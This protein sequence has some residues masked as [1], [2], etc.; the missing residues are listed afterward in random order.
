MRRRAAG[1]RDRRRIGG[2][3]LLIRTDPDGCGPAAAAP[4]RCRPRAS[5]TTPW[6]SGCH[7][8]SRSKTNSRSP[9][10]RNINAP[11]IA[12]IALPDAAE[13]RDAA[14]HD[15]GDG[16]QRVGAAVGRRRLAGIGDEGE[17]QPA[18]GGEQPRQRVGDELGA[19]ASARRTCR[20]RLPTSRRRRRRG[21]PPSAGK[22]PRPAAPRRAARPG[23]PARRPSSLPVMASARSA[24]NRRCRPG[25]G[26]SH[27]RDAEID[28]RRR[29]RRDDRLQASEDDDQRR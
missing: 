2:H 4:S 22:A 15:G 19:R 29:D 10:V 25:C 14:E 13:Q 18:D 24:L 12:P 3:R 17:E 20:R 16:E 21:R 5:S 11:K 1:T 26:R 6:N 7:S 8:G 23:S 9:M 27:E 28:R